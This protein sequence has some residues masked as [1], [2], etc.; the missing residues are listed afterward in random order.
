MSE[1]IGSRAEI[2]NGEDKANPKTIN[3]SSARSFL[4]ER[5]S[6]YGEVKSTFFDYRD[7][8]RNL[9]FY[10]LENTAGP[11]FL[12]IGALYPQKNRL[13]VV[14]WGS[15]RHLFPSSPD[16]LYKNKAVVVTGE[17]YEHNGIVYIKVS[18]PNEITIVDPDQIKPEAKIEQAFDC[19][20]QRSDF[21]DFYSSV[22]YCRN[23]LCARR[24]DSYDG[25]SDSISIERYGQ[26]ISSLRC[27][28]ESYLD[29][30]GNYWADIEDYLQSL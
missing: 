17:P 20:E 12:D 11:T 24:H 22:E 13:K 23:G 25:Y 21:E 8:E 15:D 1:K 14:I 28:G 3:W 7:Y 30:E 6:L 16:L 4:G 2:Y 26:E 10:Q 19:Y 27:V 29:D 5:V 9:A 18:S